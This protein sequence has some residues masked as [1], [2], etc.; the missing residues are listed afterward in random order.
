MFQAGVHLTGAQAAFVAGHQLLA[1]EELDDPLS[2]VS[3][4]GPTHVAR[5]DRVVTAG[6]DHV[7][8]RVHF[9][10]PDLAQGEGLRWERQQDC[11]FVVEKQAE[12]RLVSGAVVA[13]SCRLP[14]PDAQSLIGDADV[15][16][17]LARH[18]VP[19]QVMDPILDASA[20][21]STS[22]CPCGGLCEAWSG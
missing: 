11:L 20:S 8:V 4:E 7:A 18:E 2:D 1:G 12:R 16:E 10:R 9:H 6:D 19:L 17:V 14:D 21:L 13:G 5:G 3:V 22:F 15:G